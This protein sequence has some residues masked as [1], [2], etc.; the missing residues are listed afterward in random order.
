MALSRNDFEYVRELL[1]TEC[2][3]VLEP[4]KEYLVESR[5]CPLAQRLGLGTL[6]ALIAKLRREPV[7]GVHRQVIDAMTTNETLFFRDLHPFETLKKTIVPELLQRRAPARTLRIWC[8]ACSTGQEPYSI[9]LLLRDNF[10]QLFGWRLQLLATDL[11]RDVLERA[12]TGRYNQLEMNRGLPASMLVKHFAKVSAD[13]WQLRE[14]V[15]SMVEFQEMNLARAFPP[16]P[17]FDL[18]FLR[19]VMIY[20]DTETK[21]AILARIR[22]VLAPDGYLFLGCAETTLNLDDSYETVTLGK[23]MCYRQKAATAGAQTF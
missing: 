1:R 7:N 12:R 14:E 21:R 18:V 11:C 23:T 4:G 5:L 22:R 3:I 10:P 15:R 17:S 19:N 16:M 8:G 20:F 9:A 13:Q 6:D 2:A